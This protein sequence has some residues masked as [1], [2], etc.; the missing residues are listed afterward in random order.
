IFGRNIGL[1]AHRIG[2]AHLIASAALGG[3]GG[4]GDAGRNADA[5]FG[6]TESRAAD[7]GAE[8]ARARRQDG[9]EQGRES[10]KA[11]GMAPGGRRHG[12][13][14]STLLTLR[15][16]IITRSGGARSQLAVFWFR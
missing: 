7:G 15:A 5:V 12:T 11:D 6:R 2:L 14:Y 13:H 4:R 16:P 10:D 1:A 9:R 3:I 8:A